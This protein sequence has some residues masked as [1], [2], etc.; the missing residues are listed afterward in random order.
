MSFQIQGTIILPAVYTGMELGLSHKEKNSGW[1]GLKTGC[2]EIYLALRGRKEQEAGGN[3]KMRSSMI[4][5][6]K[7]MWSKQEGRNVKG[8]GEE[9]NCR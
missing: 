4:L 3:G 2:W 6:N 1:W 8:M 9:G 7:Y 5:H